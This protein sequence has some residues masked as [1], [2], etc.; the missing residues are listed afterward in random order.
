MTM[1]NAVFSGIRFSYLADCCHPDDTG[2]N[3]IRNVF[4]YKNHT[5]SHP[6]RW[7]SPPVILNNVRLEV[8]GG[9]GFHWDLWVMTPSRLLD[10]YSV[11]ASGWIIPSLYVFISCK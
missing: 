3:L 2:D 6:R 11:D 4:S 9:E 10:E 7:H 1:K 8:C 5:A